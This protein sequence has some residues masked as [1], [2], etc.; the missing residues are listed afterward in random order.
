M[1]DSRYLQQFRPGEPA[2][3]VE[4]AALTSL[5]L[6][7]LRSGGRAL[8][9]TDAAAIPSGYADYVARVTENKIMVGLPG[10][11]FA[12]NEFL[13]RAQM[14]VLLNRLL[15]GGWVAPQPG[16][17]LTG[18]VRAVEAGALT[19]ETASGQTVRR[20]LAAAAAV[21]RD[22]RRVGLADLRPG[23]RVA[24][25]VDPE[26]RVSFVRCMAPE[27]GPVE[28]VFAGRVET[29]YFG[30]GTY[31]LTVYDLQGRRVTYP[32]APDVRV[33]EGGTEVDLSSV[34][35]DAWVEVRADGNRIRQISFLDT[36]TVRGTVTEVEDDELTVRRSTG[37]KLVLAVPEAVRVTRGGRDADYADLDE[38][39]RVSVRTYEGHALEVEIE[40]SGSNTVEGEVTDIDSAGTWHITIEGEDGDE[41]EYRV[42]KNAEVER[43]GE[44]IDF[45]DLEV[46]EWVELELDEDDVV[47]RIEVSEDG[48]R[49]IEGTVTDLDTGRT[50]E[51]TVRRG[52]GSKATYDLADDVEVE[53]DGD[54]LDPDEIILGSEVRLWLEGDE[55]VKIEILDDEDIT[56]EGEITRVYISS[57]K[58]T[59]RQSHGEEFTF[60][61]ASDAVLRDAGGRTIEP[62]DLEEGW[63]VELELE[64]GEV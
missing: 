61:L 8:T 6:P 41:E 59:I 13:T 46:G 7:A 27:A 2:T 42:D 28:D 50:P 55:V 64:D 47:I 19:L 21:Y 9:Y 20:N 3:R 26:G 25:V 23:L 45:E 35:E 38:G 22:G 54:E 33:L 36:E 14:A 37:R 4:V 32:V 39:D 10:N 1:L 52:S 16:G 48:R 56:V 31:K 57:R 43:D 11:R 15:E 49:A 30:D 17:F 40:T 5:A 44:E 12:P 24:A 62:E 60:R 53:R 29:L 63:E 34:T 51:I 58:L 18:T